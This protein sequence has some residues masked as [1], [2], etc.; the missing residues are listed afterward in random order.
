MEWNSYREIG[1]DLAV[2]SSYAAPE[3]ETSRLAAWYP[4]MASFMA[5]LD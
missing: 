3:N 1:M 5:S 4:E 2:Q